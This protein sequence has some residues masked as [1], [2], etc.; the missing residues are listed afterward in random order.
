MQSPYAGLQA[1][2]LELLRKSITAHEAVRLAIATHAEKHAANRQ[3]EL[4]AKR[5]AAELSQPL[6]A[7]D[8]K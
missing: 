6:K 1:S 7:P 5:Q 8:G 2:T 4:N 3:A